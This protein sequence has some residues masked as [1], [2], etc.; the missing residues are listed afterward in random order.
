MV[1]HPNFDPVGLATNPTNFT[2]SIGFITTAIT[3]AAIAITAF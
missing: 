3:T 1:I 2:N